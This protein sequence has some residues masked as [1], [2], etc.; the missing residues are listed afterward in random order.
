MT[1]HI[2][3]EP[4]IDDKK[5]TVDRRIDFTYPNGPRD[6]EAVAVDAAAE[7]IYVLSKR[8]IPP[9]LYALPL[10]PDTDDTIVAEF[11]GTVQSLPQPSRRDINNAPVTND[12]HWQPTGM[13]FAADGSGALI[14]TYR[15]VYYF[16]RNGEEPW[17]DA[18]GR[19]PLGLR[20]DRFPNAESV[21]FDR[22]DD[23]AF[24]TIE[25]PNAPLIRIDLRGA[26][27][28]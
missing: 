1:L 9:R 24:V 5:T 2:V 26:I 16:R 4:D 19:A 21:A 25:K 10:E 13:D 11:L 3:G 20:I 28:R 18:L 17:L 14:L 12:W 22:G 8:D 7:R 27:Q 15:G 6:A 23:A